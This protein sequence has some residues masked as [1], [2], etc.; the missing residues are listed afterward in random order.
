MNDRKAADRLTAAGQNP[1]YLPNFKFGSYHTIMKK[2]LSVFLLSVIFFVPDAL[3]LWKDLSNEQVEQA[4]AYGKDLSNNL[5]VGSEWSVRSERM[6]GWVE[7][8]TPFRA[9][10]ELAR[11]YSLKSKEIPLKG[12]KK[13]I[14]PYKGRLIF[15]YYHYDIEQRFTSDATS[16]YF[17]TLRTSADKIIYPLRYDKGTESVTKISLEFTFSSADI[18]PDSLILL[19]IREPSG[20][21]HPFSFDLSRVR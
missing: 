16:E 11:E 20:Y 3:A 18:E 21:E 1:A 9:L 4:I 6:A 14:V 17:A 15:D 8:T 10:A 19:L 5:G 2:L 13:A 12:I 7:L